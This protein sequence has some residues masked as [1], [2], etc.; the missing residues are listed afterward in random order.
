MNPKVVSDMTS[1]HH[2]HEPGI[3]YNLTERSSLDSQR[4]YTFMVSDS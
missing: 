2:I 4:P 3:L 1:L